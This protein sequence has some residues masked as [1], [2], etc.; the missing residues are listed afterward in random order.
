MAN[1]VEA[2]AGSGTTFKTT[3]NAGVHTGHVNVDN[4]AVLKGALDASKEINPDAGSATEL[5]LIRGILDR[6]IGLITAVGTIGTA[7]T[8]SADVA[9][10]QG[11][12]GMRAV[13]SS[14]SGAEWT[15]V[16]GI[17][18]APFASADATTPAAVTDTPADGDVIVVDDVIISS[19]VETT[20]TFECDGDE[21]LP[22][23]YIAANSTVQI[24][25]RG[26]IVTQTDEEEITVGAADAG[27]ISV[28]VLYHYETVA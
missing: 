3:D 22:P 6:I 18:G 11:V 9:T 10:V 16:F 21:V 27:N 23:I 13:A 4:L 12:N 24:T 8:P 2:T 14:D 5:S 17:S 25:P 7:G 19:A 20:L 1:N 26:K 15:Q 28:L